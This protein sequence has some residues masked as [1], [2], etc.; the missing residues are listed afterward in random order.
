MSKRTLLGIAVAG[1]LTLTAVDALAG[2]ITLYERPGF[3]GDSIATIDAMPNLQRSD[4][5]DAAASVIVGNGM[6]EACT[7]AN[8]RGTCAEL[9]PGQYGD[10]DV[11]LNGA[12]RSVREIAGSRGVTHVV[13]A[14]DV[15]VT[16]IEPARTIV[17]SGRAVLYQNQN[18][19]GAF[20]V[21]ERGNAPDLDWARFTNPASSIRVESG[22]WLV[23]S[24]L[25]YGGD[26]RVLGPGNYPNLPGMTGIWSA[27]QVWPTQYGS[28]DI[29][30]AR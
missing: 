15:T 3:Q 12:V 4:L 14:P 22:S 20:A 16:T 28:A 21:V 25:G 24:D 13:V 2:R 26:C 30:Y 5:D 27:R 10:L 8:F 7:Q 23:C 1:A 18:F 29:H 17:P 19:S 11:Q 6:W 9:V